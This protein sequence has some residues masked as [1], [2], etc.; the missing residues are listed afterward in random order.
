MLNFLY[1]TILHGTRYPI[2]AASTAPKSFLAAR[3]I[4]STSNQHSFTVSYLIDSCGLSPEAALSASRDVN[5][6]TPQIADSVVAF[7]KNHGFSPSQISNIIGRVPSLLL[8]DPEKILLPKVEFFDSKGFTN[9]DIAGII[10]RNPSILE[11]S[12][13]NH[14]VPSFVFF[15]SL[16]GTNVETVN[17]IKRFS[18]IICHDL[19]TYVANINILRE[20]G[21]PEANIVK[22]LKDQP[23]V[24]VMDPVKFNCTVEEVKEMGFNASNMKFVEAVNAMTAMSK[25]TWERKVNA[26]KRWGLSEAEILV[27]FKKHP[28]YIL[29][30]EDKIER[31]MDFFVNKMG[32]ESTL[33]V[34]RPILVLLSLEKRILPR[35]SVI[36]D[37]VSKGL[38]QKN[39]Y[40]PTLFEYQ[41]KKFLEKFVMAYKKEASE[42]LKLYKEKVD[43]SEMEGEW[44]MY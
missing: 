17:A 38:V 10:Y 33:I 22:F 3:H 8:S 23:R 39:I 1:K 28:L 44:S 2:R 36:K 41:E 4:S 35:T 24:F 19:D 5:F 29:A 15:R 18:G 11:R 32:W 30:S 43:L 40:L 26:L 12:L 27:A 34:E 37:L 9:S 21:V 7:F 31:A 25:S 6:E 42:L 16:L 13:K 20:N 14:I